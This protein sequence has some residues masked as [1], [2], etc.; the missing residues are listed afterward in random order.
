M[1]IFTGLKHS[2]YVFTDVSSPPIPPLRQEDCS[3]RP[4]RKQR[5]AFRKR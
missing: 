3:Q 4:D 1:P 2:V 5:H